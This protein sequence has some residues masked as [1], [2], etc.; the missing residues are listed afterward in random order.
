MTLHVAE[1][2]F[3]VTSLR[4]TGVIIMLFN[5]PHLAGLSHSVTQIQTKPGEMSILFA[6]L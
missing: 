6:K 1:W 3:I 4:H 2:A 5:Q